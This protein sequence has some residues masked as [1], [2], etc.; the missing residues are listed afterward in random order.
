LFFILISEKFEKVRFL[1]DRWSVLRI[2]VIIKKI[3]VLEL[4][5]IEVYA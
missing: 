5:K 2:D 4:L 1:K 3:F